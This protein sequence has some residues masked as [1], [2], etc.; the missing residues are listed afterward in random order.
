MTSLPTEG[1]L[2]MDD[3]RTFLDVSGALSM[4]DLYN[5]PGTI[6]NGKNITGP[7]IPTTLG[8]PI[9]FQDLR[10]AS[11]EPPA[12]VYEDI[13]LRFSSSFS[14]VN[15][16]TTDPSLYFGLTFAV[17]PQDTQRELFLQTHILDSVKFDLNEIQDEEQVGYRVQFQQRSTVGGA[18]TTNVILD[19]GVLQ[20]I[21]NPGG[22]G[23][24]LQNPTIEV[25]DINR[26][27]T[28]FSN[29]AAPPEEDWLTRIF[30]SPR[31]VNNRTNLSMHT[32][33]T[34]TPSNAAGTI[35]F[36]GYNSNLRS[37]GALRFRRL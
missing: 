15:L 16:S 17:S 28:S 12:P 32:L 14:G 37:S 24:L 1:P 34:P 29:P 11:S 3:I 6:L 18:L 20:A 8:V 25:N 5:A 4:A 30:I 36:M 7:N 31:T 21:P 10:G 23:F 19:E 35:A 2:S 33:S 27:V 13:D 9:S 26:M 22:P